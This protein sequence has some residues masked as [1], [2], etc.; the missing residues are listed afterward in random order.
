MR[1]GA[2][3]S[4]LTLRSEIVLLPGELRPLALALS[5]ERKAGPDIA[6]LHLYAAVGGHNVGNNR[7]VDVRGAVD[8]GARVLGD[9]VRVD[10]TVDRRVASDL[11]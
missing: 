3:A 2:T 6:V 8:A 9:I 1:V 11:D 5:G 7:A 10:Q 4:L